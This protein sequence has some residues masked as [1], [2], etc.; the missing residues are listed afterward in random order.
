M[1]LTEFRPRFLDPIMALESEN[2]F[3]LLS[4]M[5]DLFICIYVLD[6]DVV[7]EDGVSFLSLILDR[8]LT[9]RVFDPTS[10]RTGELSAGELYSISESLLFVAVERADGAKRYVNG[11]WSDIGLIMPII[12]RFIRKAGFAGSVMLLFLT[13]CERAKASY[14]AE[15]FA[16]QVLSLLQDQSR[17]LVKW[18]G[19]FIPARIAELVQHFADRDAH[20]SLP[21][22]QKFLRILDMLVDMGDRR[23]AALQL[24]EAFREIRIGS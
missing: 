16:D 2:L 13:L 24:G 12:D 21:L 7:P 1:P 18:H 6:A 17:P 5:A 4:P 14:P 20:L 23:S 22:A 19:S 15:R 3:S 10:Y 11:D 8:L 9:E